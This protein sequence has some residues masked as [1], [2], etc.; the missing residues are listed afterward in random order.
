M[1]S[2]TTPLAQN[3]PISQK[4]PSKAKLTNYHVGL[5]GSDFRGKISRFNTIEDKENV[6]MQE[7]NRYVNRNTTSGNKRSK[8][9]SKSRSKKRIA[10]IRSVKRN[11]YAT[12]EHHN[13]NKYRAQSNTSDRKYQAKEIRY[14]DLYAFNRKPNAES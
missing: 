7:I 3:H 5:E 11:E 10:G 6:S 4:Y 8:K 12:D 9:K 2:K 14:K 1:S 13:L